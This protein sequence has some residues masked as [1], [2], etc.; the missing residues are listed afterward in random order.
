MFN[1]KICSYPSHAPLVAIR[2]HHHQ[3]QLLL[4]LL[5]CILK[6]CFPSLWSHSYLGPQSR[7]RGKLLRILVVC[8]QN[9]TDCSPKKNPFGDPETLTKK[10]QFS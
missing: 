5:W 8:P 1:A 4:L 6:S 10:T 9:E 2:R 3:L 7:F